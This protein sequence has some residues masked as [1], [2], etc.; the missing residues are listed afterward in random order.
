MQISW[1]QKIQNEDIHEPF[2]E[3][4][5]GGLFDVSKWRFYLEDGWKGMS[6]IK[7]Y[8]LSMCHTLLD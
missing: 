6:D 4:A 8:F 7:N 1:L 5:V 2:R 3:F